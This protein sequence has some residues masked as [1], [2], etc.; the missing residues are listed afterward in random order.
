MGRFYADLIKLEYLFSEDL[1]KGA[2]YVLPTKALANQ[3]GKNIANFERFT[4]EVRIFSKILH[5]PLVVFGI[6]NR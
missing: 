4:N 3:W 5:T 6:P 2:V 1:I